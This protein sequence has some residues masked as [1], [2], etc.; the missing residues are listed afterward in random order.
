[1]KIKKLHLRK[2]RCFDNLEIDFNTGDSKHGGLT[3]LVAKNGEGKTSVLDAIN[4]AWGPF[5]K[6]IPNT[7]AASFSMDDA[8]K[9]K[10]GIIEEL[11]ELEAIF[12]NPPSFLVKFPNYKDF[13]LKRKL[14][15][16]RKGFTTSS[17]TSTF[18]D[19]H[20]HL[21]NYATYLLTNQNPH[22]PWPLFAYYGDERLFSTIKLD[23]AVE[24]ISLEDKPEYGYEEAINPKKGY[25]SEFCNWFAKLEFCIKDEKIN[26]NE[27][28]PKLEEATYKKY[29]IFS[30]LIKNA[31][32]QALQQTGWTN[33]SYMNNTKNIVVCREGHP[34]KIPISRLSAGNRITIG[35]VGDLAYRCCRLNYK[36]NTEA[37]IETPGIV[38]IDE[39]ELHLH[40]AWQQQILPTLQKIF[41]KIQFIV[42][43]HSPQIVSSVPKECIRILSDNKVSMSEIMTEGARAEQILNTLFET[44]ARADSSESGVAQKLYK[45]TEMIHDGTWDSPEGKK[46]RKFLAEKLYTDPELISLE[47]DI[48]LKEYQRR[49]PK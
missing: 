28:A 29:Q 15:E 35:M 18:T 7:Q 1:M 6:N 27:G 5:F 40:P 39:I 44:S 4:V 13:I 19:D 45:Y 32:S 17:T 30:M 42:T 31:I 41:P 23:K 38:L 49:H 20:W 9:T 25:Y 43:T 8:I 26:R 10:D 36:R 2:Y 12:E 34:E 14:I 3:I 47:M 46:L 11:P 48:H 21:K 33:I 22:E 24:D 16:Q 37:V